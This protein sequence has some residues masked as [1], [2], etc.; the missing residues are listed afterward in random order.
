MRVAINGRGINMRAVD[1]KERAIE[2]F[3]LIEDKINKYPYV[4]EKKWANPSGNQHTERVYEIRN[5]KDSIWVSGTEW[6]EGDQKEV[7]RKALIITFPDEKAE[8]L[9]QVL[10]IVFPYE[11]SKR[12]NTRLYEEDNIIEIRNYG[13]FTIGRRSLKRECFFECLKDNGYDEEILLDDDKNKYVSILTIQDQNIQN[14]YLEE[15][16]IFWSKMVKQY[17]EVMRKRLV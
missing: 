17:K 1:S 15:R 13:K 16:L 10:E 11:F 4:G 8:T 12:C 2:I 9:G 3:D 14:D 5:N 6:L 7:N